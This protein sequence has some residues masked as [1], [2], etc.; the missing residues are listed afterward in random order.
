MKKLDENIKTSDEKINGFKSCLLHLIYSKIEEIKSM[1]NVKGV[2][3]REKET[4]MQSKY[5]ENVVKVVNDYQL[6]YEK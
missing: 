3:K 1:K 4:F 5:Y 6:K 2:S